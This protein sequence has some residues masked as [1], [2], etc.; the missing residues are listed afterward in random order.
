MKLPSP[1]L[2]PFIVNAF[3]VLVATASLCGII[4][5]VYHNS[6]LAIKSR[7]EEMK[8]K[9]RAI[10]LDYQLQ[11][12]T[13]RTA[14]LRQELHRMGSGENTMADTPPYLKEAEA[15]P[16]VRER[17]TSEIAVQENQAAFLRAEMGTNRMKL[18][19]SGSG[20]DL[21]IVIIE[22]ISLLGYLFLY[23][24]IGSRFYRLRR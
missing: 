4:T 21:A 22:L 20:Y 1:K 14:S 15:D 2:P 7:T 10:D 12:L 5:S 18:E 9:H 23:G 11:L 6:M 13:I 17:L 8:L 19:K 3:Y 24:F 16:G